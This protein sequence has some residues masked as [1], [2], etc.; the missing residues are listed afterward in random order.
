MA[1]YQPRIASVLFSMM[2]STI[3][4]RLLV[5]LVRSPRMDKTEP[6]SPTAYRLSRYGS[7]V[8]SSYSI[9]SYSCWLSLCSK[10]NQMWNTH[11]G[12]SVT[13]LNHE[14]TT[15]HHRE[16][17]PT[18]AN[19]NKGPLSTSAGIPYHDQYRWWTISTTGSSLHY[20]NGSWSFEDPKQLQGINHQP[21]CIVHS[22]A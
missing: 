18:I 3:P 11:C 6:N 20:T 8:I 9:P 14:L 22:D 10:V 19:H 1:I 21:Y 15:T 2:V 16:Q 7:F 5:K 17:I 13:T 4:R 12:P